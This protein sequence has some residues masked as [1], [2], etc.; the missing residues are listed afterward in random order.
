VIH[1][2]A[3][4]VAHLGIPHSVGNALGI[5]AGIRTNAE[6]PAMQTLVGRLGKENIEDLI[7]AVA[8]IASMAIRSN[9]SLPGVRQLGDEDVRRDVV[10]RMLR[11][12][13]LRSNPQRLAEVAV[14]KFLT[15][16]DETLQSL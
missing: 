14:E 4:S 8:S 5:V 13:C 7:S 16:V 11:D 9:T 3:H 2:F 1:A 15:F 12:V 6:T 10:Q